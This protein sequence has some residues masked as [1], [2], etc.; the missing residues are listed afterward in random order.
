M[1][2]FE[3]GWTT[4]VRAAPRRS[5]SLYRA[6]GTK[7]ETNYRGAWNRYFSAFAEKTKIME[8]AHDRS[9]MG[10]LYLQSRRAIVRA[11]NA[12]NLAPP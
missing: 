7:G 9:P 1:T 5:R 12:T 6:N 11:K 8:I 4:L 10:L 2:F 3:K